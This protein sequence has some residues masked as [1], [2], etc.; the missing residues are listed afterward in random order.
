MSVELIDLNVGVEQNVVVPYVERNIRIEL[1]YSSFFEYWFFNMKDDDTD[2]YIICGIKLIPN[3]NVL[4]SFK[5]LGFG[6][7]G[8]WDT[9]EDSNVPI[10]MREDLGGRLK[11]Y[12]DLGA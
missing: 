6:L 12:R 1:R 7:F 11:L 5:N 4:D 9:E 10:S 3:V 8:I 2:E